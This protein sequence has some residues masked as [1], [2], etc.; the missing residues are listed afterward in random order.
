[1]YTQ[2][3]IKGLIFLDWIIELGNM[4][5]T[6]SATGGLRT[7]M[8]EGACQYRSFRECHRGAEGKWKVTSED[9]D[10]AKVLYF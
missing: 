2:L 8:G 3:P 10:L 4:G 6:F 1:M 5:R 9:S 7:Q